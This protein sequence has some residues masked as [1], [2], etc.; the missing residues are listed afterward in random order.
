MGN[1]DHAAMGKGLL[2]FRRN[3]RCDASLAAATL[4][5]SITRPP[6]TLLPR[7]VSPLAKS[8]WRVCTHKEG[9]KTLALSRAEFSQSLWS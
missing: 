4:A 3:R 6:C 1:V 8:P 9:T 7:M 2:C 5:S